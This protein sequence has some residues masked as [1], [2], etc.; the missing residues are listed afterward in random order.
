MP[1]ICNGICGLYTP[2]Y[3]HIVLNTNPEFA[4][5]T[6]YVGDLRSINIEFIDHYL[7]NH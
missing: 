4:F 3:T 1:C 5:T 6:H 7:L 2:A